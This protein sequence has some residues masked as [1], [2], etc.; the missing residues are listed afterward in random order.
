MG[1]EA[2]RRLD[3]RDARRSARVERRHFRCKFSALRHDA[4]LL[5][6]HD[7]KTGSSVWRLP[8]RYS[9][10]ICRVCQEAVG[11]FDKK[12]PK[13]VSNRNMILAAV[14]G[15]SRR[16]GRRSAAR[17]TNGQTFDAQGRL[18][19]ANRHALSFLATGANAKVHA[20][21]IADHGH[22]RQGVRPVA[23]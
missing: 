5:T 19:D 11:V 21:V 12:C 22:P 20:H 18:A 2:R 8:M 10:P 3:T 1:Y 7:K 23:N 15:A 9:K 4:W 6:A 17:T 14:L 13:V 16:L